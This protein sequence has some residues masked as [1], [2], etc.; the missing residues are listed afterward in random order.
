MEHKPTFTDYLS[1]LF[2]WKKLIII[3]MLIV[4]IVVAGLTLIIDNKYKAS[5]TVMLPSQNGLG[6]GALSGLLSSA[7]SLLG[8]G[9]LGMGGDEADKMLG[10]LGSRVVLEKVIN[11]FGLIEYYE[12]GKAKRDRTLKA[13][14]ADLIFDMNENGM[15]EITM[16]HKD[17][18]KSAQIVNY[19][20]T[21]LDTLNKK[22]SSEEA[23]NYRFFVEKRHKK[24]LADIKNAEDEFENFQK[25][26]GV[27]VIPEQIEFAIQSVGEI[28]TQ[29]FQIEMQAFLV[30]K[31]QGENAPAYLNFKAQIQML[32]N[33]LSE[34]KNGSK[35]IDESIVFFPFKKAPEIQKNYIRLYREIEIQGKIQEFVMP[36]YEQALME[37]QKNLPT[38]TVLDKAVPPQLKYSPKRSFIVLGIGFLFFFMLVIFVFRGEQANNRTTFNNPIEEKESRFFKGIIRLFGLKF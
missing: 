18:T 24:N 2:K 36:I 17:T 29:L 32:K 5:A 11:K 37:E 19:A 7:G 22:I 16:L 35:S 6:G 33:K 31:S 3:S 26:Y 38:I 1:I 8:G 12:F 20:V 9:L 34:L 21:L 23:T 30:K 10:I 14:R 25:K 15:I 28:E 4:L 27:F 13:L